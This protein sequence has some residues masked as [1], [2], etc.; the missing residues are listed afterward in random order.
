MCYNSAYMAYMRD[1]SEI[2]ASMGVFAVGLFSDVS[3]IVQRPTLVAI[4]TKFG[5]KLAITQLIR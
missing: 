5:S 2:L 1:M 4:S 3:Q